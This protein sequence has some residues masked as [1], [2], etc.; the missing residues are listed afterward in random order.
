MQA[1]LQA[2]ADNENNSLVERL[3]YQKQLIDQT[4]EIDRL[5]LQKAKNAENIA[6]QNA[7]IFKD[8]VD[9]QE[10]AQVA[11]SERIALEIAQQEE[12]LAQKTEALTI[13]RDIL[14][15]KLDFLIDDFDNQK[16]INERKIADETTTFEE[17]KR[18]LE[19]N[20]RLADESYEAQIELFNK[21]ARE[22]GKAQLDL[23]ALVNESDSRIIAEQALN[24]GISEIVLTRVLEMIRERRTVTQDNAE[25]QKELNQENLEALE[26]ESETARILETVNE[27][28]EEG[29]D[30]EKVLEKLEG[31]VLE[32]T[33]K[34]LRF[35]IA[36][37][38]EGSAARIKL[39][40]DLASALLESETMRLDK[41]AEAAQKAIDRNIEMQEAAATTLESLAQKRHEKKLSRIDEQLD[42][43]RKREEELRAMAQ[44]GNQ[45]AENNL[46]EN[47]K[48]QAELEKQRE[49]ELKRQ[50]V[51]ELGLATARAYSA[52]VAA[53]SPNPLAKTVSDIAVL[54]AFIESLTGFY[55]GTEDTG[56]SGVVSDEHGVITGYTH[57]KERVMTAAQNAALP[58]NTSN[59]EL[60][61]MATM[62]NNPTS[63]GGSEA[64]LANGLQEVKNA[65]ERKP[66]FSGREYSATE[67]A[68]V[69]TYVERGKITRKH[70]KRGGL[71]SKR[72]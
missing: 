45:D 58:S 29:V 55:H 52:N 2:A 5:E 26:I 37:L 43:E 1:S 21:R 70:Y 15:Q 53:G 30:V 65:I 47:Q 11:S 56:T 8:S 14:E 39:E 7:N 24:A 59:W 62:S 41:E 68:I 72:K 64:I 22:Q 35:K 67:R 69:D 9:A 36:L 66:V 46:A 16:T 10:A 54:Q 49:K 40:K 4:V 32:D 27:L 71:I 12:N 25:A 17:R 42:A 57:A 6:I 28:K 50:K 18:L 34:N 23:E 44:Q 63:A 61:R 3:Q 33:I 20:E 31:K 60:V 13:E 51:F 19:E 48:R 38:K